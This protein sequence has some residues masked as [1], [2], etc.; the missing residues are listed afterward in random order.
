[1]SPGRGERM[2]GRWGVPMGQPPAKGRD[3]GRVR[4]DPGHQLRPPSPD[5]CQPG[6][7]R[8]PPRRQRH[9][10]TLPCDTPLSPGGIGSG[11]SAT[12]P[13]SAAGTAPGPCPLFK[14]A[15]TPQK[16]AFSSTP[17]QVWLLPRWCWSHAYFQKAPLLPRG[18][19]PPGR[20]APGSPGTACTP[21]L[22]PCTPKQRMSMVPTGQ[23]KPCRR[24]ELALSC[25]CPTSSQ[26][27]RGNP[28]QPRGAVATWGPG[29]WHIPAP[30]PG[31]DSS[32]TNEALGSWPPGNR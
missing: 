13:C 26:L 6:W 21:H 4:Q 32:P 7:R 29:G 20:W 23:A 24:L 1:M 15:Q 5:A 9:G 3:L 30:K 28:S 10:A 27:A 12:L 19:C 11:H 18:M 25:P 31:P 8:A 14:N 22:H 17:V 2:Q 16:S